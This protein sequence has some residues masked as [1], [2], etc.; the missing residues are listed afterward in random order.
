MMLHC[1]NETHVHLLHLVRARDPINQLAKK[2]VSSLAISPA[3]RV[4]YFSMQLFVM[5]LYLL[6]TATFCFVSLDSY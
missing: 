4:P 6:H 3:R 5:P 1:S 2:L